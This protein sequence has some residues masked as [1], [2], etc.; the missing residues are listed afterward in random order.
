MMRGLFSSLR[1]GSIDKLQNGA[2]LLQPHIAISANDAWNLIN[3]RSGLIA[4]LIGDGYRIVALA[5]ENPVMADALRVLGCSFETV[6]IDSAGA[7][8]SRDFATFAAYNKIFRRLRPSVLLSWTVKP[9]VYGALAARLNGMETIPN[10]SGLGTAFIHRSPLTIIIHILY[11]LSCAKARTVFFQNHDD[12]DLF[13][14]RGLVRLAQTRVLPGS[15]I[16]TVRFTPPPGGRPKARRFVMIARML[17]DKGVREFVAAA[18]VVRARYPNARFVLNGFLDAA[19]RTAISSDEVEEWMAAGIIE[20]IPPLSDVRPTIA[21]A[22]FIV[23][24]SYREGLSRVLLEAAAMGR[25]LIATDVPGCREIVSE[26]E[27][28]FLCAPRDAASLAAAMFRA[29]AID[30]DTWSRMAQA[31]R[32]RAVDDFEEAKVINQYREAL[33]EGGLSLRC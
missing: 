25:P 20:Y 1:R 10:V 13:V 18:Q 15:G 30:D 11:K 2:S 14:L 8:L 19:N 9:N 26:G 17:A 3:F 27:N 7:S 12:R 33:A 31:S 28:G 23:L 24:P 21:Q 4:A 16:D 32:A 6:P 29:C 22:D 5:P